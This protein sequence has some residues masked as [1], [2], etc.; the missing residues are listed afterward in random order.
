MISIVMIL[1]IQHRITNAMT[2]YPHSRL[3]TIA[4]FENAYLTGMVLSAAGVS[5]T[6]TVILLH[7]ST[8]ATG[9]FTRFFFPSRQYSRSQTRGMWVITAAVFISTLRPLYHMLAG[10]NSVGVMC[11]FGYILSAALQGVSN[12]YK[13]KCIVSWPEPMD[14]HYITAWLLSYQFILAVL[15]APLFYGMQSEYIIMTTMMMMIVGG[16]ADVIMM[17]FLC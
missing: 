12:L 7:A 13:E 9:L 8:P 1:S 3:V 14:I 5:P 6:M 15:M 4:L 2:R 11:S 17:G 10:S 16:T